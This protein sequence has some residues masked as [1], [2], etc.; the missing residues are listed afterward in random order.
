VHNYCAENLQI[1]GPI[2]AR[3]PIGCALALDR[4]RL[5]WL[6]LTPQITEL[7]ASAWR[8]RDHNLGSPRQDRTARPPGAGWR[9]RRR[10]SSWRHLAAI[11]SV[12]GPGYGTHN[13]GGARAWVQLGSARSDA[14]PVEFPQFQVVGLRL[15]A[16]AA[17]RTAISLLTGWSQVRILPAEPIFEMSDPDTW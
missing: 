6:P 17:K 9:P 15:H 14:V 12:C 4:K 5:S 10:R 2:A 7:R 16:F 13:C 8:V 1:I 11:A 3:T